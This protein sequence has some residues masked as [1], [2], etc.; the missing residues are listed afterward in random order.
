MK[1]LHC[2]FLGCL[3]VLVIFTSAACTSVSP[4][5]RQGS[6]VYD[7]VL[8]SGVIRCGYVL[9]P[10]YCMKDPNTGQ[11]TGFFV[12][13]MEEAGKKLGLKVVWAE[14]VGYESLFEGLRSNRFDI[15]AGGLWP[16]AQRARA[17]DF[18]IPICYSVIKA[19][20]R[21][22][23]N[24]FNDSLDGINSPNVTVA[25]LD[26]AMESIIARENFPTAKCL[27]LPQL[28]PFS[29]NLLNIV[30]RK[31]DVTFAE[32]SI[33]A[34]FLKSN[35]GTLKELAHGMPIR[36]FGNAF[37]FKPGEVK[38]K[39]M[40]NV[41]LEELLN[42]GRIEKILKKYEPAPGIFY[43]VAKPYQLATNQVVKK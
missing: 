42:S 20:G 26:G 31:A 32:P 21:S 40:F 17:G 18:S 27:A 41:A 43:R 14:E 16:N 25:V 6:S 24:R 15:F 29:Q 36:V 35:P 28:S 3:V 23:E 7:R 5:H 33:V 39:D 8:S 34:L 12:D 1:P 4:E 22:A 9:Y 19:Y 11:L 38:F 37:A 30:T 10:P 2:V 13:A